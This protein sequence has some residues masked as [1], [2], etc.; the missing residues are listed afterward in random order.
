[1][2]VTAIGG[3]RV[4]KRINGIKVAVSHNGGFEMYFNQTDE[5]KK[6]YKLHY[7][8]GIKPSPFFALSD[9]QGQKAMNQVRSAI[10]KGVQIRKNLQKIGNSFKLEIIKRTKAGKDPDGNRQRAYESET[11]IEKR[12][13]TGKP[14]D[15]VRNAFTGSMLRSIAVKKI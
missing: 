3:N 4:L 8:I 11:Y 10:R 6:A 13:K 9:K 12:K 15:V 14:T 5:R 1:M 7:G 2:S